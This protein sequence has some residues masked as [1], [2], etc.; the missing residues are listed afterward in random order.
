MKLFSSYV[1]LPKVT[2][3]I[4]MTQG[5]SS[6]FRVGSDRHIPTP[7]SPAPPALLDTVTGDTGHH[8]RQPLL[9]RW[10]GASLGAGSSLREWTHLKRY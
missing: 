1:N 6:T 9:S 2:A 4:P 5:P 8:P 7:R 10:W 3:V